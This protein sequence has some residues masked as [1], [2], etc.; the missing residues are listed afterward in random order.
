MSLFKLTMKSHAQAAM[1]EP[2]DENPLTK[3]WV[4]LGQ[5]A[6]MRNRLSEF[7]KVAEIAITAVLGSVADERTFSTLSFMKSKAP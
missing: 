6:L 2:R 1:G 7:F 4:Q 3:L 5:N